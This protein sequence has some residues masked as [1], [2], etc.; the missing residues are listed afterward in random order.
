MGFFSSDK[1]KKRS[2]QAKINKVDKQIAEEKKKHELKQK[3]A[4]LA[5]MKAR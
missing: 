1:P 4:A 3:R 2:T 5:K